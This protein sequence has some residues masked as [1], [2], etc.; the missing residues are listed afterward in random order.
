MTVYVLGDDRGLRGTLRNATAEVDRFV[1]STEKRGTALGTVFSSAL[2]KGA[3]VGVTALGLALAGAGAAAIP[4]EAAMRNVNSIA[5]QTEDAFA[6][7]SQAVIDLSRTVPQSATDLAKGLYEINSSGFQGAEGLTVLDAAAKAAS[8]GLTTTSRAS[9][10]ISG[11]LNAYGLSASSAKDVSDILFQTVNL[12]VVSFDDLAQQLG[13]FVGTAAAAKVPLQDVAAAYAAITLSGIPAAE[14]ATSVNQ[15][16]TKLINPG[17]DLAA[18]YKT[19]GYESGTSA[20]QQKGLSG[21]MKDLGRI[22]GGTSEGF[23]KLFRDVR[24]TRG[25]LALIAADGRNYANALKGIAD[26]TNRADATQKAFT[27]QMKSTRAQLALL[28]NA[29]MATAIEVGTH[30][31]PPFNEFLKMARDVG[32]DAVP[33][34]TRAFDS[35]RPILGDVWQIIGNIASVGR[36][37][38]TAL[39]PI[40]GAIAAI[41]AA[42]ALGALQGLL[43]AIRELTQFL[44]DHTGIVQAAAAI[45]IASFVPAM[46]AATV[47]TVRQALAFRGL[48]PAAVAATGGL[49]G[50]AAAARGFA[51]ALLSLQTVATVGIGAAL[52]GLMRGTQQWSE[53]QDKANAHAADARKQFDAYDTTKAQSQLDELRKTA[54]HGID[55]G[56]QYTGVWG[57]LKAG[58]SEFAGDGS[59]G[60]VAAEGEA[61]AEAYA[62]L[63]KQADNVTANI[64]EVSIETGLSEEALRKLA[65]Q[66]GIDLTTPFEQGADARKRLIDYTKDLAKESTATSVA[67]AQGAGVD[68]AAMA[69]LEK[70]IEKVEKAVGSAF[71]QDT[72]VLGSFKPDKQAD[73]IKKAEEAL[74]KARDHAADVAGRRGGSESSVA[75][76]SRDTAAAVQKVRDAEEHLAAVRARPPRGVSGR[77]D[78]ETHTNA[79]RH[80][81][82]ALT[83]ARNRLADVSG[84]RVRGD[85]SI[86]KGSRDAERATRDVKKAE[87]ALAKARSGGVTA[88]QQLEKQYRDAVGAGKAFLRDINTAVQKGLDPAIVQRLLEA[89]P[90]K[91]APVL[92][93]IAKDHSGRLVKLINESETTLSHLSDLAVQNAR[94]TALAIN[95]EDSYF[96]QHMR[97]AMAIATA[98]AAAGGK[99]TA[100]ALAANL[101][102]DP[103]EVTEV[104]QRFGIL[105]A[106]GVQAAVNQRPITVPLAAGAADPN[107]VAQDT[108][109][110]LRGLPPAPR[111][112]RPTPTPTVGRNRPLFE[113][114][115]LLGPPGRDA[116]VYQGTR[117]EYLQ[118]VHA[119]QYYGTEFMEKIRTRTL[120]RF[121]DGGQLGGGWTSPTVNVAGPRVVAVPVPVKTSSS[122][123]NSTNYHIGQVAVRDTGDLVGRYKG[124]GYSATKGVR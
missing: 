25:A 78:P 41:T 99:A 38:V 105:V 94:I 103:K 116:S 100:E 24:A 46:V 77:A 76:G 73:Q 44:A 96:I 117:G 57:Q 65:Q 66:Q 45:Y 114:G 30:L 31:L 10:A 85:Q 35:L 113:G 12:G 106:D 8:A 21:V 40:A 79:V 92:Q 104:A 109:R 86:A 119:V 82:E 32:S 1:T 60:K 11:A 115:Q 88:A 83:A 118:P 20:L 3:L 97:E 55:V 26:P 54:L 102:L 91:A 74:T 122:I 5:H 58:F 33:F 19:L 48:L 124:R 112:R 2:G 67:V 98:E 63:S 15:V 9:V 71:G 50:A 110:R 16:L 52:F 18:A 28:G 68:Q 53:A 89:G 101:H 34:V 29:I 69:A 72:D 111:R 27:E 39:G 22:T 23:I 61:A 80:A 87:D 107:A 7:T 36:D 123:D 37:L 17:K 64:H 13:D 108:F 56:R 43:V 14:A 4:F 90:K 70:Q 93:A 42:V 59:V 120:P 49:S 75:K 81:E 62:D 84:R 95:N 6:K 121:F 51:A 47:A